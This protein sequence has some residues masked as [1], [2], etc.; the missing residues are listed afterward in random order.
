MAKLV[1]WVAVQ[2]E[3]NACYNIVAKTKKE[4]LQQIASTDAW[5]GPSG[6]EAPVKKE[7]HYKDAL[8]LLDKVTGDSSYRS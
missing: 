1:Y 7:V 5:W 8:D 4:C 6:F 3:D 2:N